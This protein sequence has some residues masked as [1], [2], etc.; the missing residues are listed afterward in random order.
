MLLKILVAVLAL[1]VTA[2]AVAAFLG[3]RLP[4]SHVATRSVVVPA[5]AE[6]VFAVL[7]DQEAAPS[8]RTGLTR[9]E[10]DASGADGQRRYTEISGSDRLSFAVEVSEPPAHLVTRIVGDGLP[11]GGTW[12]YRLTP[13]AGGTRVTITEHGEVYNPLFRFV[14]ARIIGHTATLDRYLADLAA[15]FA[16]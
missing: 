14:S 9:V 4:V 6:Q 13:E 3:S 12:D 7:T 1:L 11:F 5:P 16:R 15:K 8:W 10:I 2:V